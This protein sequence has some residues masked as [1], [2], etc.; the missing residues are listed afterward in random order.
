MSSYFAQSIRNTYTEEQSEQFNKTNS[1]Y[2][3]KLKYLC[4]NGK[5]KQA[6][7]AVYVIHN[8]FEKSE[9]ETILYE[10]FKELFK[11]AELKK[12]KT[13]I[14]CLISLG[15]ICLLV[16]HLVG[17]EIK[18]FVSKTIAKELL[19]PPLGT[20]LNIADRSS[21]SGSL[22]KKVNLKNFNYFANIFRVICFI[23]FQSNLKLA[24][25]WCE[26]EDELP[27]DTRVKVRFIQMNKT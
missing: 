9:S 10:L 19:L 14:P 22:T 15:H 11:E 16:P 25:K 21:F 26:N 7:F 18:E 5:P 17:K 12:A 24:G 6:K 20:S 2:T 13:F 1:L 27:F 23:I 4:K 8:N 3:E